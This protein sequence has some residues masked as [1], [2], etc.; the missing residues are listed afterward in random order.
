MSNI[1]TILLHVQLA[2]A[3]SQPIQIVDVY[4]LYI[5]QKKSLCFN[6]MCICITAEFELVNDD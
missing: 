4:T 1:I 6:A 3:E 2:I 5:T